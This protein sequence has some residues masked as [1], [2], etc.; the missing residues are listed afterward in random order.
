MSQ[1]KNKPRMEQ[2]DKMSG[3]WKGIWTM[4]KCYVF[5]IGTLKSLQFEM[6]GDWQKKMTI[7]Q[8]KNEHSEKESTQNREVLVGDKETCQM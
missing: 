2:F 7:I 4:G 3:G 8:L 5:L 1:L 6:L